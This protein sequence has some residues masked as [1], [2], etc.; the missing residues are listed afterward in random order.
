[1]R[2]SNDYLR[3]EYIL[4]LKRENFAYCW[5]AGF[6]LLILFL[7]LYFTYTGFWIFM[8]TLTWFFIEALLVLKL[9]ENKQQIEDNKHR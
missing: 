5:L 7:V 1:M 3:T 6:F 9:Y 4:G 8:F 2:L